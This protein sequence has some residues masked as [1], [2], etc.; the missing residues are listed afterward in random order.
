VERAAGLEPA[1]T[2][3]EGQ[4]YYQLSYARSGCRSAPALESPHPVAVRADDIAL[5]DLSQNPL[6]GGP[7]DHS[8]DALKLLAAVSMIK[9]HGTRGESPTTVGARN[10]PR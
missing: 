8:S 4:R 2:G 9:F 5:V 3:L 7:P 1:T 10:V 6:D